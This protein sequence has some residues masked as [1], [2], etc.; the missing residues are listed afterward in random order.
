MGHLPNPA[1][2]CDLLLQTRVNLCAW[3]QNTEHG[4]IHAAIALW[5][6]TADSKRRLNYSPAAHRRAGVRPFTRKQHNVLCSGIFPNTSPMH[7]VY[8]VAWC[9][10]VWCIYMWCSFMWC[11]DMGR[12]AVLFLDALLLPCTL[13]VTR[14][15][16]NFL[17]KYT[18]EWNNSRLPI[19]HLDI[20]DCAGWIYQSI[21][22]V[23]DIHADIWVITE[24]NLQQV[25]N[26]RTSMS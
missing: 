15:L 16:P 26:R 13:S 4:N 19:R 10:A 12:I 5:S 22:H 8:I 3:Q 9:I 7:Y 20:F 25:T 18:C 1:S 2:Q 14:L 6:A 17:W 21:P 24:D 23:L 11:I